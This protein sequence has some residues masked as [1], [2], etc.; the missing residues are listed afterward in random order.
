MKN[1]SAL[2]YFFE[3]NR[4][5]LFFYLLKLAGNQEDAEDIFQDTFIKY[6]KTY[7]DLVSV[8]LLFT[9]AKSVFT[10]MVRGRKHQESLEDNDISGGNSPEDALIQK[11]SG[12]RIQKALDLLTGED[13]DI[14]TLAGQDGLSYAE[15]GKLTKLSEAN[16]KVRVFRAR[17]KLKE[18]LGD[19]HE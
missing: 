9:V 6:A 13:R 3:E 1:N 14:L 11:R 10:D 7:P 5:K 19:I 4:K 16:V 15:I 18:I 12:S 17:K 8:P 2:T